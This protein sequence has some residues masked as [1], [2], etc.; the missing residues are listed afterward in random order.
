M[1]AQPE[2]VSAYGR[3]FICG[4]EA[5][6]LR[7][8]LDLGGKP[9]IGWGHLLLPGESYPDGITEA[10]AD[11]ILDRDLVPPEQEIHAH[12][13]V[14]LSQSQFDALVSFTFNCGTGAFRSSTLLS[15]LNVGDTSGAADQFLLWCHVNGQVSAGLLARR[16]AERALFLSEE[17]TDP[18]IVRPYA[19]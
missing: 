16:K 2:H 10:E 14:D 11:A 18:N 7:T 1:P 6:R 3:G 12:C 15:K 8:Y 9:T 13:T 4:Y 19:A 17:P 5:L